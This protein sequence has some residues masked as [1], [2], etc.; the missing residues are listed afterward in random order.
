M[1]GPSSA[2]LCSTGT[3][4]KH[5]R[6]AAVPPGTAATA[7]GTGRPATRGTQR[8]NTSAHG[9]ISPRVSTMPSQHPVDR[10]SPQTRTVRVIST[11]PENR[12]QR[13]C[14]WPPP[15]ALERPSPA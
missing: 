11:G 7:T 2:A 3:A 1:V 9:R 10:I 8:G 6:A 4:A 14:W 5:S 13:S 12:R 15:V